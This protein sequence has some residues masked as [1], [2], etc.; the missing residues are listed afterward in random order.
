M[1][2]SPRWVIKDVCDIDLLPPTRKTIDLGG[3][4]RQR[5]RPQ[6]ATGQT[7]RSGRVRPCRARVPEDSGERTFDATGQ[8]ISA[9][10]S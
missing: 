7:D 4:N 3:R 6:G 8:R 2:R 5:Q 1:V 9:G 10:R